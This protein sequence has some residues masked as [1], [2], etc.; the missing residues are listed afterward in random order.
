MRI[1][2]RIKEFLKDPWLFIF[3]RYRLVS[4]IY[5]T[6]VIPIL[7]NKARK[8]DIINVVFVIQDLG[9]W[10]TENLYLKMLAH[11]RFS[12]KLLLVP[13]RDVGYAFDI[14]KNYLD[15]RAYEYYTLEPTKSIKSALQSDIIF[16]QKPYLGCVDKKFDF[17]YNLNSLICHVEYCFRNRCLP[18]AGKNMFYYYLWHYYLENKAVADELECILPSPYVTKVDTGIPIMDILLKSR[19][20]FTN[21]WKASSG[22]RRIIYAPHHTIYSEKFAST[23]PIDYATFLIYAD[24]M[25]EMAVK[26]KDKVQWAFKPH[27]LL[28]SKLYEIWGENQTDEYYKFWKDSSNTQLSEGE[29]MGLF[30]HSDAM[31]HDCGSFKLEYLYTGNP[32]L[33]L[34]K[35]DQPF[36]YT[37]W[38]T[39][40]ALAL[41]YHA[42]K[43]EE[44]EQFIIDV[45]NGT[46]P[47]KEQRKGFIQSY[48]TPKNSKEACDNIIAAILGEA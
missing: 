25:K 40:E 18:S 20:N 5:K 14:L 15:S 17:P 12:P 47:L 4:L 48:L 32:V 11:P 19:E 34:I 27:P 36:D 22:K 39:K 2:G 29:Y 33:Y 37:N 6:V 31:I 23:S 28:K 46:D 30:K 38:Q 24:F 8:K 3:V 26:Y 7:V 1:A 44:I 45:I 42:K 13:I 16:F 43:K 41:H 9:S 35:E 21:P 10:K